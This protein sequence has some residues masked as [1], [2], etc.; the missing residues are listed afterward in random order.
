M[1]ATLLICYAR[2][3]DLHWPL[4]KKKSIQFVAGKQY[5]FLNYYGLT[6]ALFDTYYHLTFL[7]KYIVIVA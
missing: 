4:P 7:L 2:Y 3:A 6:L 1:Y 5:H